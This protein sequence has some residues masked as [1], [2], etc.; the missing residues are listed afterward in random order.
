[1]IYK[2]SSG[3]LRWEFDKISLA[4]EKYFAGKRYALNDT[5]EF[6]I[7][8]QEQQLRILNFGLAMKQSG[9]NIFAISHSEKILTSMTKKII[10]SIAITEKIPDDLVLLHNFKDIS[11]PFGLL[12]PAGF[13]VILKKTYDDLINLIFIEINNIFKSSQYTSYFNRI[14]K[15]I[16]FQINEFFDSIKEESF[17]RGFYLKQDLAEIELV[18][19]NYSFL[20]NSNLYPEWFDEQFRN[21]IKKNKT[22][23]NN[24]LDDLLCYA[25]CLEKESINLMQDFVVKEA[26]ERLNSIFENAKKCWDFNSGVRAHLEAFRENILAKLESFMKIYFLESDVFSINRDQKSYE[27]Y[28]ND[29]GIDFSKNHSISDAFYN[30]FDINLNQYRIQILVNNITQYGAPVIHEINPSFVNLFGY[31]EQQFVKNDNENI[32]W[33]NETQVAT[34]SAYRANGGYLVL[35]ADSI[36]QDIYCWEN[37]KKILKN[38]SVEF[39]KPLDSNKII[40]NM[41][42]ESES[43]PLRI[44]VILIGNRET[45]SLLS[46]RDPDFMDLFKIRIDFDEDI[47]C[48]SENIE[49]YIEFLNYSCLKENLKTLSV[50]GVKK[51]IEYCIVSTGYKNKIS[52]KIDEVMNLIR[53]ANFLAVEEKSEFIHHKHIQRSI[54]TSRDRAISFY[55]YV[56]EDICSNR[57]LIE[58]TGSVV[59][60]VNILMVLECENLV[61]G[62]PARM[63]CSVSSGIGKFIDIE[64]ETQQGGKLHRRGRLIMQGFLANCFGRDISIN[65]N[66]VLCLEQVFGEID[67]DSATLAE[68][69]AFFSALANIPIF[70]NIGITGSMD[71]RG[72]VQIIG[73]VNEKIEG[74]FR[75][76]QAKQAIDPQKITNI[77]IIPASNKSDLHLNEDIVKACDDG[78]FAIYSAENFQEVMQL[79]TGHQW[80][81]GEKSIKG[82]I[83]KTLEYFKNIK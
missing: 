71:Q 6:K 21:K 43:I 4:L 5:C 58:T 39:L 80:D 61:F 10:S 3:E 55:D 2:L 53:E 63:T 79:I 67:G 16:Q 20:L 83:K 14:Q 51:I 68:T 46:R 38:Q 22:Y 70:Q 59:G 82:E 64:R 34:G 33:E 77:V 49:Y 26:S 73:N 15:K 32:F 23:L 19:A 76:C 69:C 18:S 42:S 35:S 52:T 17:R 36:L 78:M 72:N 74:F 44:K 47:K 7:F 25:Q 1:M 54:T 40:N 48:T 27:N 11:N 57:V 24:M 13:G 30:C 50:S 9:F 65:L 31:F 29:E 66:T 62:V 81:S 41:F 28:I 37:L 56:I 75:V 45:Y 60:Q 8:A 12:L